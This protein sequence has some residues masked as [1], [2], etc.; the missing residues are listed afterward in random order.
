MKRCYQVN[1][2]FVV[3]LLPIIHW[4][5]CL[6]LLLLWLQTNGNFSNSV[7]LFTFIPWNSTVWV[8]HFP[9]LFMYRFTSA[10]NPWFLLYSVCYILLLLLWFSLVKLFQIWSRG[11]SSSWPLCS[12]YMSSSFSELAFYFLTLQNVLST[13]YSFHVLVLESAVSTRIPAYLLEENNT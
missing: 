11:E 12:F 1:I 8:L 5:P 10:L 6:N 3:I 4:Y 7:I 9:H 2:Q 13:S